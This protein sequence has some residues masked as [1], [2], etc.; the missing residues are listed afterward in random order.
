MAPNARVFACS[1][2]GAV[3]DYFEVLVENS[4]EL[5]Q[6]KKMAKIAREP[7]LIRVVNVILKVPL[8]LSI[9]RANGAGTPATK[10][11][12]CFFK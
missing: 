4:D 3:V 1:I 11:C 6:Q 10:S 8:T 12:V 2:N 9:P 5:L 7:F